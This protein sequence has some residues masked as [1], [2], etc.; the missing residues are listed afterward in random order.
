MKS[1][2]KKSDELKR[3]CE[4]LL[5]N[6]EKDNLST[7]LPEANTWNQFK[8]TSDSNLM[9]AG[10]TLKVLE[11]LV[12]AGYNPSNPQFKKLYEWFIAQQMDDGLFPMVAGK[13][14]I[15][16]EAVSVRAMALIRAVE[17]TR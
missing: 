11:I 17:S 10:G 15:A 4:F 9:F 7:L 1:G 3:A 16:N 14:P 12:R 8:I 13:M 5:A 2:F 6:I